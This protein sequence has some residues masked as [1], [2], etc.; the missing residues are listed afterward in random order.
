MKTALITGASRGIGRA[1]AL[2]FASH[3]YHTVLTCAHSEADLMGVKKEIEQTYHTPC[4]AIICDGSVFED[5][6]KLFSHISTLDVL[7]NNAGMAYFGL[8]QDMPVSD[9]HRLIDTNLSSCFYTCKLAIPLMLAQGR[10]HI[11]NVSSIWGNAGASMET[12]YSASKGGINAL[13]RALSKELAP[14]NIPVNA[15]AFGV[16]DTA[17]NHCLSPEDMEVLK[18]D[19]PACRLG[20]PEEAAE[21]IW[22]T[23][24]APSYMTGQIITM[25][26]GY[27]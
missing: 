19:I 12:A 25:A 11:I 7:V 4:D 2:L 13:T 9:W 26:G 14:S 20:T 18:N 21:L 3:G 16:I 1:T 15:I 5:V 17:M 8:L 23:A 10:G 24:N 22:Q 6:E 27:E